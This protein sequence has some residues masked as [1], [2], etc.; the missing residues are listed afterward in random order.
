VIKVNYPNKQEYAELLSKMLDQYFKKQKEFYQQN[1]IDDP[2][3][4]FY[5]GMKEWYAIRLVDFNDSYAPVIEMNGD[6]KWLGHPVIRVT[7]DSYFHIALKD[8]I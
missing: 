2:N 6:L 1:S 5:V 8:R 7:K 3:F 4:I